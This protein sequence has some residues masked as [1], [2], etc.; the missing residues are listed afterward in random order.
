MVVQILKDFQRV[1]EDNNDDYYCDSNIIDECG[2]CDGCLS[3]E[4]G[5]GDGNLDQVV[6]IMDIMVVIDYLFNDLEEITAPEDDLDC[7][8]SSIY[9]DGCDGSLDPAGDFDQ[10]YSI[11]IGENNVQFNNINVAGFE[12][13]SSLHLALVPIQREYALLLNQHY[14]LEKLNLLS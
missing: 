13:C 8:S 3:C 1:K 14:F 4:S 11:F 12:N 5:P 6:D 10:D 7:L 2:Q 9:N